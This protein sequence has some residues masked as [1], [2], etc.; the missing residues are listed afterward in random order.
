MALYVH[1]THA[2]FVGDPK[3]KEAIAKMDERRPHIRPDVVQSLAPK[4]K[5]D[6][7]PAVEWRDYD[8]GSP[9]ATT[10][11]QIWQSCACSCT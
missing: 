7:P 8:T 1:G 9:L 3:T 6:V 5:T 4:E 10:L 11:R 2:F